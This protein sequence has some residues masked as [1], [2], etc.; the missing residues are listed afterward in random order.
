MI[1]NAPAIQH[2]AMSISCLMQCSFFMPDINLMRNTN[3]KTLHIKSSQPDPDD[4]D[5]DFDVT[6]TAIA[7]QLDK[8]F[9]A[10]QVLFYDIWTCEIPADNER[11]VLEAAVKIV[12]SASASGVTRVISVQASHTSGSDFANHLSVVID[13]SFVELVDHPVSPDKTAMQLAYDQFNHN[14]LL[15]AIRF[16][17]YKEG[18][19]GSQ[20]D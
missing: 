3:I 17:E 15:N 12:R 10:L 20:D 13:P 7:N 16:R 18:R 11:I 6:S 2:L 5:E 1:S 14:N 4:P 19:H 9:P 8:L